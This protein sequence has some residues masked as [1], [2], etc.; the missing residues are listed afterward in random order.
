MSN[1]SLSLVYYPDPILAQ[2]AKPL[3]AITA[4]IQDLAGKMIDLMVSS[5]GIG[6]AGPQV[7]FGYRIFVASVTGKEED[8]RVFINP[9][10]SNL[11]GFSEM[12]EGCLSLPGIHVN[13]GRPAACRVEAMDVDGQPFVI[14]ATEMQAKVVQH[15]N[16]HLDGIL[17]IDKIGTLARIGCRKAIKQLK[18]DYE[19]NR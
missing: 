13:V 4:E 18:N 1:N 16:D 3:G 2:V 11:E 19:K 5:S 7:G 17:I 6:L 9:K 8:A 12:E 14:D 15:E 10:I